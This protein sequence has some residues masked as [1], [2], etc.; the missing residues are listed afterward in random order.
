MAR[1]RW[2]DECI[3]R[4]KERGAGGREKWNTHCDYG[5]LPNRHRPRDDLDGRDN[6]RKVLLVWAEVDRGSGV[7]GIYH[8][9]AGRPEAGRVVHGSLAE[10]RNVGEQETIAIAYPHRCGG[11]ENAGVERDHCAVL[12]AAKYDRPEHQAGHGGCVLD[13]DVGLADLSGLEHG[14]GIVH[15]DGG[16]ANEVGAHVREARRGN[17]TMCWRIVDHNGQARGDCCRR[18]LP[19]RGGTADASLVSVAG[20]GRPVLV[21]SVGRAGRIVLVV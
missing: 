8:N 19:Q 5:S 1:V 12:A 11:L 13:V 10:E 6:R 15:R 3:G 2:R 9:P 18:G 4:R 16:R 17:L 21:D 14:R 7:N 20:H